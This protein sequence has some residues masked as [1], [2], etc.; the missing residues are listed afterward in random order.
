MPLLLRVP[1]QSSI[2]SNPLEEAR[3]LCLLLQTLQV[4]SDHDVYGRV[5][6]VDH[7]QDAKLG[8]LEPVD[9]VDPKPELVSP[10]VLYL[11]GKRKD[12]NPHGI[13]VSVLLARR[14]PWN[15]ERLH[16]ASNAA[17]KLGEGHRW[18]GQCHSCSNISQ[19]VPS[20]DHHRLFDSKERL[21]WNQ[22]GKVRR[23]AS[24]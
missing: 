18:T 9:Q 4:R 3:L 8:G 1:C 11:V 13:E 7:R 20:S 17:E 23:G 21:K 12:Q 16:G 10:L 2:A 22:G 14:T 6:G 19:S 15:L 5:V 24:S